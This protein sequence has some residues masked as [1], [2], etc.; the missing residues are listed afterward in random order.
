[1]L[2]K[3]ERSARL[4]PP[5]PGVDTADGATGTRS[6]ELRDEDTAGAGGGARTENPRGGGSRLKPL[7]GVL[8]RGGGIA[9]GTAGVTAGDE[10]R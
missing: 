9:L 1:M 4:R 6:G 8:E 3:K 2:S 5:F 10:E 7:L